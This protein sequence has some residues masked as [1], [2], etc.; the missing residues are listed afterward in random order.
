MNQIYQ[1]CDIC[2]GAGYLQQFN[3][4]VTDAS[5]GSPCTSRCEKCNGTG[6]IET[7]LFVSI[8]VYNPYNFLN[9][10]TPYT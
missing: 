7:N 1:K 10:T 5:G 9:Y 2:K 6:F 8:D 4:D 3:L